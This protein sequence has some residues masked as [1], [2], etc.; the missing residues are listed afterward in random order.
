MY[1]RIEKMMLLHDT[2][3][4]REVM[5]KDDDFNYLIDFVLHHRY[6]ASPDSNNDERVYLFETA[7]TI[8]MACKHI[9][10][11]SLYLYGPSLIID[12]ENNICQFEAGIRYFDNWHIEDDDCIFRIS[13][14]TYKKTLGYKCEFFHG[15]KMMDKYREY[16][17][18]GID[19]KA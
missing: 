15:G 19:I 18:K 17:H 9:T 10:K 7:R 5:M 13:F 12:L 4:I 8:L 1:P 14:T 11:G 6:L 16:K 3:P 2:M